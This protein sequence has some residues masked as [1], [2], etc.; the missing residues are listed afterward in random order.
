M[1]T[2]GWDSNLFVVVCTYVTAF[3]IWGP[4]CFRNFF[5]TLLSFVCRGAQSMRASRF[6]IEQ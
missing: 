6:C 4:A 3:L 5:H 2:C 1:H